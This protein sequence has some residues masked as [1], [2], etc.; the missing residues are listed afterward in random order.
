MFLCEA[1]SLF[2]IETSPMLQ[3]MIQV[4]L[5]S[6]KT[7]FCSHKTQDKDEGLNACS[8][9]ISTPNIQSF[10]PFG[11]S[12]VQPDEPKPKSEEEILSSAVCKSK[13]LES[14]CPSCDPLMLRFGLKLKNAM[15]SQTSMKCKISGSV[16]NYQNQPY[17]IPLRKSEPTQ[18]QKREAEKNKNLEAELK[19]TKG[20]LVCREVF[21]S[22]ERQ[23]V[24]P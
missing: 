3:N 9:L 24:D 18:Q 13:H 1:S 14:Q 5:S 10:C 6:I 2:H 11:N 7:L 20:Y 22:L 19:M 15:Q 17:W 4:G 16:M 12:T 21:E 23:E 8:S